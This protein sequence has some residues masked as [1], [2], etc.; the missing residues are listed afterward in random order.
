MLDSDT[1]VM[2]FSDESTFGKPSNDCDVDETTDLTVLDLGNLVS[3]TVVVVDI[4]GVVIVVKVVV[5]VVVVLVV[6]VVAVV[7]MVL[8]IELTF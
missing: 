6:V 5:V 8:E 2:V 7:V 4:T 1:V 3:S